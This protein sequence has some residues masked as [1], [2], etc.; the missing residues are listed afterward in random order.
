MK[1]EMNKK[2]KVALT[3]V[4][5]LTL[6]VMPLGAIVQAAALTSLSDTMTRLKISTASDHTIKFTTPTGVHTSAK[7]ITVTFPAGFDLATNVVAFGDM[8]LSHGATTGYETEETLAATAAVG[9]WGAAV[10]GQVVTFTSPT[11]AAANEITAND[12]VVIEIGT[13]ASGGA[14]QI[15]NPGTTGSKRIDIGGNFGDSGSM[16]VSILTD[17]QVVV[18]ATVDPSITF[19]LSTT[20]ASLS[21]IT[22]SATVTDVK[23]DHLTVVT[24]AD[25]GYSVTGVCNSTGNTLRDGSGNTISWVTDNNAPVAGT[26][27][28][29]IKFEAGAGGWDGNTSAGAA[30]HRNLSTSKTL[31]SNSSNPVADDDAKATYEAAAG[32]LTEAGTYT[33]TI[34]YIATG[35]F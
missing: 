21:N 26:E 13:N 25:T 4:V 20:T 5:A 23:D 11:D 17:E 30:N 31:F 3:I 8:D 29:G 10:A 24:N 34:T 14:N 33:A 16:A 35:N 1:T 15:I 18:T 27:G 2:L 19:T 9:T 7:T 6:V 28:W 12:K 22:T 32:G